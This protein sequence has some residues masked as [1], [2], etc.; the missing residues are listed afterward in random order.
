M[1]VPDCVEWNISVSLS[2]PDALTPQ[3]DRSPLPALSCLRNSCIL[4][5]K[6]AE[7][8]E[9]RPSWG[10][11]AP[12]RAVP[13]DRVRLTS[14]FSCPADPRWES[15]SGRCGCG[16]LGGVHQR[17]QRRRHDPCGGTE[18]HQS[19]GRQPH[20]DPDKVSNFTTHSKTPPVYLQSL[21]RKSPHNSCCSL[22]LF[23][24]TMSLNLNPRYLRHR[25]RAEG[26]LNKP[27]YPDS[28]IWAG[29]C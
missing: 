12:I 26:Y 23:W 9:Y 17:H 4:L 28:S 10:R 22:L 5:G 18:H 13:W 15:S 14:V 2:D 25:S 21:V 6:A 11:M 16:R 1:P 8:Q 7:V 29:Q 24:R 19:S 3:R 27:L 20:P